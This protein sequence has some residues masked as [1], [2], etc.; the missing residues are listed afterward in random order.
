L[1][2]KWFESEEYRA[3]FS[4]SLGLDYCE[5]GVNEVIRNVGSSFDGFRYEHDAQ[6]MDVL[7]RWKYY[8]NSQDYLKKL[9]TDEI[10]VK[11]RQIFDINL[12]ELLFES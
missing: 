11:T 5:D 10:I 4:K 8:P 2:D 7:N 12:Q 1:F 3:E 9:S 6:K